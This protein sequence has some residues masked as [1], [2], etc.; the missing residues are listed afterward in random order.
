M[1]TAADTLAHLEAELLKKD[2]DYVKIRR[3]CPGEA[4]TEDAIA[5]R[6]K[7]L[8]IALPPSYR[9]FLLRHGRFT[10]GESNP[11]WDHLI[12]QTWP[13]K[14]HRTALAEYAAQ[15]ECDP[16]A[17]VVADEIGMDPEVV[18]ALGQIVYVGVQ[19]HEDFIGFD[20]R[21]RNEKTGECVFKMVLFDDTEIEAVAEEDTEPCEGRG[22][23][24]W[25]AE[26]I[27]NR[28]EEK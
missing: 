12:Y 22:F 9:E 15:L 23:D 24:Q 4:V 6:E 10:I 21:T 11:K 19:G 17:E 18:A 27:E 13:L 20:L 26:H 3:F 1:K 25:L 7:A 5:K 2:A 28:L 8:K 16:T 14:Q